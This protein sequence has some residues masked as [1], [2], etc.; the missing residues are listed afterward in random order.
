[1]PD[2]QTVTLLLHDF[3]QGDK[4]AFDRLVPLV[5]EELRRIAGGHLHRER[6][7]HTLQPTALVHEVYV[8]MVGQEQPDYRDRAHFLSI[9][10]Q[11]MRRILID[12]ARIK[13][14]AKRGSGQGSLPIDEARD[15][16][17]RR[18]EA[19]IA[20]DDALTALQDADPRKARLIEMRYFGG[21]TI[22]ECALALSMS[23][24]EVRREVR[25]AQ[26]WLQRE[27]SR[28]LPDKSA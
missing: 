13:N 5:Y 2:A 4:A 1:V 25:V 23:V 3:A 15:A 22:E 11:V 17:E 9:A 8:R 19:L 14:A 27:L 20:L 21:L 26:A 7:G 10:A 28:G 24:S 16:F 18:P 6:Q 12:H